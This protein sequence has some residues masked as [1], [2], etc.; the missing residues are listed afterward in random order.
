[1]SKVAM[2]IQVIG[3]PTG[4]GWQRLDSIIRE[5]QAASLGARTYE[6][7]MYSDACMFMEELNQQH[8]RY[9]VESIGDD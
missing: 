7:H 3:E 4:P 2:Q 9:N 8:V 6:F 1:M 5:G